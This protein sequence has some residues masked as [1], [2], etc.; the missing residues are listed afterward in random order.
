MIGSNLSLSTNIHIDH[1]LSR[2]HLKKFLIDSNFW[3][4]KF[5]YNQIDSILSLQN[6]PLNLICTIKSQSKPIRFSSILSI[7]PLGSL[8]QRPKIFHYTVIM[9]FLQLFRQPERH[10][11]G[12]NQQVETICIPLKVN[13]RT[14]KELKSS[15]TYMNN[16]RNTLVL[17]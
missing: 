13:N 10:F 4:P 16:S 14:I 3:R 1:N 5:W 7:G 17:T 12:A 8:L 11:L 15:I 2:P 9:Q 6:Y